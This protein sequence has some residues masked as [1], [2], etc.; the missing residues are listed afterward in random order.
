MPHKSLENSSSE[1]AASHA[2]CNTG[3]GGSS[4]TAHTAA[5]TAACTTGQ[6]GATSTAYS[7]ALRDRGHPLA[8]PRAVHLGLPPGPDVAGYW[9]RGFLCVLK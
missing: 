6:A 9:L 5:H 1:Q 8:L 2:A 7:V 3:S 4:A